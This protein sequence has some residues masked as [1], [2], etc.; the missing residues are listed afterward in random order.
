MRS[1]TVAFDGS[2]EDDR[3]E[4]GIDGGNSL[5]GL[6]FQALRLHVSSRLSGS[7]PLES[8]PAAATCAHV[9]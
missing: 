7:P 6:R 1:L 8:R 2:N 5:R 4:D 9:G 3:L